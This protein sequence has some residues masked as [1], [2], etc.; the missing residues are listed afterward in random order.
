MFV[1][2]TETPAAPVVEKPVVVKPHEMLGITEESYNALVAVRNDLESG[3]IKK[4]RLDGHLRPGFNMNYWKKGVQLFPPA[5]R[6]CG[7]CMCIGGY[8]E[9]KL[10][11]DLHE[12]EYVA[13]DC[14]FYPRTLIRGDWSSIKPREA[15]KAIDNFI[16]TG[17]PHWETAVS[18]M[19]F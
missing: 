16:A 13:M 18:R 9:E 14:L 17:N 6:G 4:A 1:Q 3:W 19:A 5:V 8:I 12:H 2:F 10:G 15:V 11:H 7:T